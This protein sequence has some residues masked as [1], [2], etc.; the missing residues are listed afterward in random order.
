MQ[1]FPLTYPSKLSSDLKAWPRPPIHSK[2]ISTVTGVQ[3][4]SSDGNNFCCSERQ[5]PGLLPTI[6]SE[7]PTWQVFQPLLSTESQ[8]ED[9]LASEGHHPCLRELR[10]FTAPKECRRLR[11]RIF[12]LPTNMSQIPQTESAQQI[13]MA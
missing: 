12:V 6:T 9:T 4:Q 8:A 13:F 11:T 5:I 2:S 3:T 1:F 7:T 10:G